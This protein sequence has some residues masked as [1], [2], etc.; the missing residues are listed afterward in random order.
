ME[1]TVADAAKEESSEGLTEEETEVAKPKS[2]LRDT[3]TK[4]GF[5]C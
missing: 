4:V 3:D 5:K 2:D 1:V